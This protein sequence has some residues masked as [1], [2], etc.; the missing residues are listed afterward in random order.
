MNVRLI[1]VVFLAAISF[2]GAVC[3]FGAGSRDAKDPAGAP[4]MSVPRLV[5]AKAS[6]AGFR[7]KFV[8]TLPAYRGEEAIGLRPTSFP[9]D[10]FRFYDAEGKELSID[11]VVALTPQL[12][13]I[14]L[15]DRFRG[16]FTGLKQ[17]AALDGGGVL[18]VIRATQS[19]QEVDSGGAI[20]TVNG[21]GLDNRYPAT[22]NGVNVHGW[23]SRDDRNKGFGDP[24]RF[25]WLH[26]DLGTAHRV[27]GL[28][29]WNYNYQPLLRRC[30]R[31]ID[32]YVSND[33]AALGDNDHA[34]WKLI[35]ELADV[36]QGPGHTNTSPYGSDYE[37][38]Q[39]ML[40]QYVRLDVQRNWGK[41]VQHGSG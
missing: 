23:L 16:Q 24:D 4:T 7:E 14:L 12:T 9:A 32:V 35:A 40:G 6:D 20:A 26:Y 34:S 2:P 18:E 8:I 17:T 27:S 10:R 30:V 38:E 22:H 21:L 1:R 31:D 36:P 19:N 39:A 5:K 28:R 37:F 33:K 3:T 11:Q 13:S 15:I 25:G 29:I 41:R